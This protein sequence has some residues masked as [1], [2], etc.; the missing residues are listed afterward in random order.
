MMMN[1]TR[2]ANPIIK[3]DKVNYV[4]T[5]GKWSIYDWSEEKVIKEFRSNPEKIEEYLAAVEKIKCPSEY[6]KLACVLPFC[7]CIWPCYALS[8]LGLFNRPHRAILEPMLETTPG[9]GFDND[10]SIVFTERGV[11]GYSFS[12]G[13]YVGI[14][15]NNLCPVNDYRSFGVSSI[16]YKYD[17][18]IAK[19]QYMQDVLFPISPVAELNNYWGCGILYPCCG[20]IPTNITLPDFWK[21]MLQSKSYTTEGSGGG[22]SGSVEVHRIY[23]ASFFVAG[24]DMDS[25]VF[26]AELLSAQK[27][28]ADPSDKEKTIMGAMTKFFGGGKA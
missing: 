21:I 27:Q 13:G 28:Y 20:Y 15:W 5:N 8:D 3:P 6:T 18:P 25:V 2:K 11:V 23:D 24:I 17:T 12:Y 26:E 7:I 10:V 1:M 14:T 4:D 19:Y 9:K 16:R 22:I